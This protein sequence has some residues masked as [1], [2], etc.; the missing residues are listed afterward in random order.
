MPAELAGRVAIVTGGSVGLGRAMSIALADAGAAVVVNYAH[1]QAPADA[2]VADISAAG[3]RA[4]AVQADVTDPDAAAALVAAAEERVGP[5]DVL[6][7]NATGP[8][9]AT[10]VD[11]TDWETHLAQ[12]RFAVAAPVHVGRAVLPGMRRAG[13]GRIVNIG[14][15]VVARP[16]TGMSA[17]ATA[18]AALVGLTRAWAQELGPDGI[19]VNCVAPGFVPVERHADVPDTV[20]ES[21]TQQVP[22]ARMGTP[23]EIADVVVFLASDGARFLTGQTLTANGGRTV[24]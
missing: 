19:T 18:K 10:P 17:Y 14:S 21:Y 22:L 9:P 16:E 23:E 7:N 2:T 6:V 1:R 5:V 12:L 4:T 20:R 11:D 15:E 24:V 3:G 13:R 8:Q